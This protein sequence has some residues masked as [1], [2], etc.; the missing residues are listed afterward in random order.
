MRLNDDEIL[1][2]SV[3]VRKAD[4]DASEHDIFQDLE[5]R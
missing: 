2:E 3:S 1:W 4:E 5:V